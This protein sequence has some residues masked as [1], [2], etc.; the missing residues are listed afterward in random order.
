[1]GDQFACH[2][3]KHPFFFFVPQKRRKDAELDERQ[4]AQDREGKLQKRRQ[5]KQ[6]LKDNLIR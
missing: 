1:M 6:D 4:E 2:L 5:M 3:V